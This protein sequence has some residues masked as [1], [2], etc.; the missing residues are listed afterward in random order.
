MSLKL[1]QIESESEKFSVCPQLIQVCVSRSKIKI[2]AYQQQYIIVTNQNAIFNEKCIKPYAYSA[3]YFDPYNQVSGY[4][5]DKEFND[6]FGYKFSY[7]S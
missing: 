6:S 4:C 2:T 1:F 3:T 5:F 7:Q